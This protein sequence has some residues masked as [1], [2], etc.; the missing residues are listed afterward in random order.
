MGKQVKIL[1]EK[2]II[3]DWLEDHNRNLNTEDAQTLELLYRNVNCEQ[4]SV[5][6]RSNGE[7][8]II[9]PINEIVNEHL[10]FTRPYLKLTEYSLLNL[11]I[12]QSTSGKLRWSSIISFLPA[13]GKKRLQLLEKTI[14][15]IMNQKPVQEAG[16]FK[17]IDL[18]GRL[19]FQMEFKNG[20]MTSWGTIVSGDQR[21]KLNRNRFSLKV[22]ANEANDYYMIT[23]YHNDEVGRKLSEEYLYT[24]SDGDHVNIGNGEPEEENDMTI[25]TSES[26]VSYSDDDLFLG[27]N[28]EYSKNFMSVQIAFFEV[29]AEGME[30]ILAKITAILTRYIEDQSV[31]E[32]RSFSKN[33]L[34]FH[35]PALYK[36]AIEKFT[37]ALMQADLGI[38]SVSSS[39]P[40]ILSTFDPEL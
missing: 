17:F 18:N 30:I 4:L 26:F 33:K 13:A 24:I 37:T 29:D 5:E 3:V 31:I 25:E 27:E 11:M 22:E 14:E 6:T 8:I 34:S 36:S 7:N 40:S 19:A 10:N 9:I 15:N 32:I 35:V 23:T 12:V 21:P 20:A 1:P 2:Q 16:M 28:D 38:T 39:G